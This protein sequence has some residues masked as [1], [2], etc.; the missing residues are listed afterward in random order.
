MDK[1]DLARDDLTWNYIACATT[2]WSNEPCIGWK[3][4]IYCTYMLY[5]LIGVIFCLYMFANVYNSTRGLQ[6]DTRRHPSVERPK[7][8][9]DFPEHLG[10][11]LSHRNRS[12]WSANAATKVEVW[13]FMLK[14]LIL[15]I[16]SSLARSFFCHLRLCDTVRSFF[17]IADTC[18]NYI[19]PIILMHVALSPSNTLHIFT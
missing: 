9:G 5:N 18:R 7:V 13:K 19:H 6:L 15:E 16:V 3:N 11:R 17:Y 4:N 12:G 8:C 1:Q 2:N 14:I 10:K